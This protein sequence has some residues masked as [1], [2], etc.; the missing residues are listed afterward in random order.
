MGLRN[1]MLDLRLGMAIA[2]LGKSARERTRL[3]ELLRQNSRY[4]GPLVGC[5][6]HF[7][8]VQNNDRGVG[9]GL[10]KHGAWQRDD[11]ET[12]LR[13]II[14]H[15]GRVSGAFIDVG[16]NIGTHS[17]YAALTGHFDRVIAIEPEPR[18]ASMMR[19]NFSLNELSV[20]YDIV[21]KAVGNRTG[22]TCL[23]L[24]PGDTGM[25]SVVDAP[26]D[27][28]I[29]V[30]LDTL[31]NIL[32]GLGARPNQ[33][34]FIWMDVE[35]YE[36]NVF[37]SMDVLFE[38]RIPIFFEYGRSAI[39]DERDYWAS[40]FR[41]FGYRCWIFKRGGNAHEAH[42]DEALNIEFGNLLLL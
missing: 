23:N 5:G 18:N 40:K 31:P 2:L 9:Q 39:A 13:L 17:V 36:F 33:T 11:F 30:E 20:P 22:I 37:R 15:Y 29:D 3:A 14:K 8:W 21:R 7:M 26:G 16:A 35:G 28:T 19:D 34:G 6:D 42:F 1:M 25:H 27:Q 41:S 32:N 38:N 12:A 4:K 10:L 24:N